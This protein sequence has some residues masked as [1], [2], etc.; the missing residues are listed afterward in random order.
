MPD[1]RK[2]SGAN[3][4]NKEEADTP[5]TK[6]YRRTAGTVVHDVTGSRHP[7][8]SPSDSMAYQN[9]FVF[10]NQQ[11]EPEENQIGANEADPQVI[12]TNVFDD[13]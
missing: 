5:T 9:Q 13:E 10:S 3:T 7:H 4:P 6:S 8:H 11:E 12:P 1:S 2:T